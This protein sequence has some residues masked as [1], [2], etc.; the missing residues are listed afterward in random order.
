LVEQRSPKPQA[1][2]SSPVSPACFAT[3]V[4][5]GGSSVESLFP[6]SL[7]NEFFISNHAI[8]AMEILPLNRE[9]SCKDYGAD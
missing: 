4:L 1:A 6:A 9:H 3:T 7:G 8:G 5:V 2:G